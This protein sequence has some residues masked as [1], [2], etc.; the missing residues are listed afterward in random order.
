MKYGLQPKWQFANLYEP[1]E[2][3]DHAIH[4]WYLPLTL[5][6]TQADIAL[7]LL[8][9]AQR[10]KHFRR[11]TK[12]LQ[13]S[14]LAG[15]FYLFELLAGYM[16]CDPNKILLSYSSLNKPYLNPNPKNLCFNFTDTTANGLS[17]GV[18]AFCQHHSVGVD[19][20]SLDRDA[21][22]ARIAKRKFSEDELSQV[23]RAD[24]SLD[25]QACVAIWTRKEAFGKAMGTGINY[26]MRDTDL[27][28]DE[29][30]PFQLN[31][32]YFSERE[33]QQQDWRLQQLQIDDQFVC[34]VVHADHTPLQLS[35]FKPK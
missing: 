16:N 12:A 8:N 31:F 14:Y 1:P 21:D 2:L 4:L 5:S 10:D 25:E 19:I 28:C 9:D 33:H 24:G 17:V 34:S 35:C 18:Y 22:F 3:G 29:T 11:K 7:T 30:S 13:Q 27:S 32:R 20:E 6:D 15:R 26:T 23:Y